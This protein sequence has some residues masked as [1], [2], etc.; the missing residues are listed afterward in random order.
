MSILPAIVFLA[1]SVA[2]EEPQI[3]PVPLPARTEVVRQW[4]F[5]KDTDGWKALHACALAA[6]GGSLKIRCTGHDPYFGQA[7]KVPGEGFALQFKIRGNG[8][9]SGS[10]YWATDRSP[11]VA[12][13]K[14]RGFKLK[15]DG[16]WREIT[17]RLDA[18]GTLTYLR[19]DPGQ[20]AGDVEIASLRLVR[21]ELPPVGVERIEV[22][23]GRVRVDLKNRTAKEQS[24]SLF[25]QPRTIAAGASLTLEQSIPKS[26]PVEAVNVELACSGF[27]TV[28]RT[29]FCYN[30][31]VRTDWI[32]R[33]FS[34]FTLSVA[35][36]GG[37]ARIDRNGQPAAILAPLV[38]C[39]GVLPKLELVESKDGICFRGEGITLTLSG[40]D[41]ELSVKIDSN[42]PCE[43]PVVRALG[44]LEQGLLAGLEYLGK[45]EASSS[46]LD[47]ETPEHLRFAPDPFQVTMPLMAYVTDRGAVALTWNDMRLQ[48]TFATP[49]FFDCTS[50]HRMA[51]RGQ[52]IEATLL[53]DAVSLEETIHWAVKRQGL[54]PL[55]AAPRT[56]ERQRQLCLQALTTGPL[57]TE[58]GWGH[59]VESHWA[60]H[61][62][63]DMASTVWR[64]SGEIP[65]L[66]KLV[67][68]GAHVPNNAIYFVTGRAQVWLDQQRRQA[69]QFAKQQQPDGSYHY[70][71]KYRRGHFEDTAN[72]ICARPAVAMLE[73][74]RVSGDRKI[75]EAACRTLDYM[76][77]FDVPRGAQT[78]EC[79]LHT[80]DILASAYL[81]W[82]YVR[83]YELT[84]KPE[85]LAEARR[86][87][88]SGVPFVYLWGSEPVMLYGTIAVYGA[89][90]WV[91]PFWIGLPVQWCGGVYAYALTM[92]APYDSSV[93]WKHLARGILVAA[94]Q[95]Q[96]PDGPN[97]GL[98][99]DSF[100]LKE[101]ERRPWLI[102]PCALVSLRMAL[103]GQVD[104]LVVVREGS[105]RI[106][107]PFPVTLRDG[108]AVIHG[109]AGLT[110]Q[111]ILDGRVI[112]VKSQGE[113]M[114]PLP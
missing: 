106:V 39:D 22:A 107:A 19:I 76:K 103:D 89:T 72:G 54:P 49:N 33:P 104:S 31:D 42:R 97:A 66:P 90:N 24:F 112:D 96:F 3:S 88:L 38:H 25:G 6:E 108:K 100:E 41:K 56:P 47:V 15:H 18:A 85:Y 20:D 61:P 53:V 62:H 60:R 48:P 78:W 16:Q 35:R 102:N 86:W 40:K 63:A 51:L 94:E 52:R 74:A 21:E 95:M 111:V 92:L 2:A 110:Y 114:L 28:R 45:G 55:P 30:A 11:Q 91:A 57:K 105:H 32:T 50:D 99:P 101:Q 4:N 23:N 67:P 9:G 1:C 65:Q 87:A 75:L 73:Y 64:L 12:Q 8:V 93:D 5:A 59:C 109:K 44:S 79:A 83:G 58:A 82:A 68:G 81:V 13:D 69:E 80:P 37:M 77:R 36:D 10:V 14:V 113:D 17:V 27:P 71:G 46:K 98:L 43:G 84:G 70:D 26:R 34:G 29:L 7:V